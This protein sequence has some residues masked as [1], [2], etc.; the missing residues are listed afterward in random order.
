MGGAGEK[1]AALRG[2]SRRPPS[3]EEIYAIMGFLGKEKNPARSRGLIFTGAAGSHTPRLWVF[4]YTKLGYLGKGILPMV[5]SFF[6]R[7]RPGRHGLWFVGLICLGA[8]ARFETARQTLSSNIGTGEV[9]PWHGLEGRYSGSVTP[10]LANCGPKTQGLMSVGG[11]KFAFDPFQSTTV[12]K[13]KV[14][15]D[16][17]LHGEL[18]RQGGGNQTLKADFEARA[19]RNGAGGD[20]IAGVLSSGRCRWQ[21]ILRRG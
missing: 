19:R 2:Y 20:E 16:G 4:S 13:G 9:L 17:S 3:W 15:E 11:G 6:C 7:A 21:V 8:C 12:I 14:A 18:V 5:D 10:V 1:K